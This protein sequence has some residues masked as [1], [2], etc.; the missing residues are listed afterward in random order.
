VVAARDTLLD[1]QVALKLIHPDERGGGRARTRLI[2]EAQAL[3][4]LSH[5][6]VV[7]V[8]EVGVVGDQ[9]SSPWS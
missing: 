7:S 6:N 5:P 3:A 8:Y 2:R 9:C 1:R 4:K